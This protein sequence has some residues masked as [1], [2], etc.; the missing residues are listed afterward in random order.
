MH[1]C[2]RHREVVKR[3]S[4]R[5]ERL[6]FRADLM[7]TFLATSEQ[8]LPVFFGGMSTL[9][10]T[11]WPLWGCN[12]EGKHLVGFGRCDGVY[13]WGVAPPLQGYLA[14]KKTQ[15]LPLAYGPSHMPIVGS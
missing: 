9:H 1:I 5:R 14:H 11:E 12:N 6:Q 10:A 3:M 13:M 7:E 8:S 4:K 2:A 15:P